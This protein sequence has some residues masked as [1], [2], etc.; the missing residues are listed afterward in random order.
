M[1][2]YLYTHSHHSFVFVIPSPTLQST[3]IQGRLNKIYDR[4][5]YSNALRQD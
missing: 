1:C 2:V 3:T 4:L 5:N